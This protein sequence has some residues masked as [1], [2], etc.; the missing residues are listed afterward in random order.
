[1]TFKNFILSLPPQDNKDI[2]NLLEIL[3]NDELLPEDTDAVAKHVYLKLN[4]QLTKCF[5][6]LV[7]MYFFTE[8]NYK[9]PQ[10]PDILDKINF[11]VNL[12]NNDA[13]YK[14]E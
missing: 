10:N 1:M 9:Q 4:S 14:S 3:R 12:Q 5:Q 8:N 2:N 11:I 7:M 6:Q 13:K